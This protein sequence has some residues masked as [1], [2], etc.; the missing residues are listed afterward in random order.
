MA[1]AALVDAALRLFAELWLG[2]V[3]LLAID[4]MASV[5]PIEKRAALPVSTTKPSASS[6]S[7]RSK[8]RVAL[9]PVAIDAQKQVAA[10]RVQLTATSSVSA[11]RAA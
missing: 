4:P 6:V 2:V 8:P 11:R 1:A 9:G 3:K 7:A 5:A 10:A